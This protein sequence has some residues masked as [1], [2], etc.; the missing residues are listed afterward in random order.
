[1]PIP[2][3]F[4][5]RTSEL[6]RSYRYKDWSGYIA[7]CAYATYA[8]REYFAFRYAAG[9]IDVTPLFKYDVTGPDAASFLARVMAR[10][11]RKLKAQQ[12][13]YACWCDEDGKLLDDGTVW[14]IDDN[15][16]RVTAADHHLAWFH[17]NTAGLNVTITDVTDSIAA[18]SLQGPLSRE[19]LNHATGSVVDGLR[20]FR[21]T[22]TNIANR[23]VII[24]RT[25]Y[26]G[27]LGYEI[28]TASEDAL[29][30]YDAIYEAGTPLGMQ[31]AGLDAMD[32]TRIEA[33][34]ILNGVDYF[35]ANHCLIESRKSTPLEADLAWTVQLNREPF[36]GQAALKAEKA[37]GQD[38]AFV[39]LVMEWDEFEAH[40]AEHGLPPE[41]CS[42]AWR[43]PIPIY[44]T[45]GNHVGQATSGAW[46]PM[47][48]KNLALATVKAEFAT[49]GTQ[50]RMETTVEYVR[51]TVPVTVT[52]KPFYNPERKRK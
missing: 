38:R 39:G 27:D 51:K 19:I 40:F 5:P 18:L 17:R 2:T 26:T 4:H 35:S 30:V 20:F 16:Y 32:I 9:L 47:L 43:D 8:D 1:M 44:D 21:L 10:D 42:A 6:C 49:P 13:S 34:F 23:D 31:P 7:V 22:N 48:K 3:P 52:E 24:T 46:S 37:R 28:W 11:I 36:I 29:A 50:L 33:G 41:I 12:V 25:G 45:L 14:R 15:H